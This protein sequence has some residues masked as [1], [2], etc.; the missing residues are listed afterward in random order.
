MIIKNI[1]SNSQGYPYVYSIPDTNKIDYNIIK[2]NV[3][4]E[5]TVFHKNV[6]NIVT[7]KN[8]HIWILSLSSRIL[9]FPIIINSD[10]N[11]LR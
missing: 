5:G 6:F 9:A 3:I 1:E 7:D 2:F 10:Y 11:E 4:T 8:T